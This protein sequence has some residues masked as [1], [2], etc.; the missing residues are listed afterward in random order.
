MSGAKLQTSCT[1]NGRRTKRNAASLKFIMITGIILLIFTYFTIL[2]VCSFGL[3]H[4]SLAH[5]SLLCKNVESVAPEP[6][7]LLFFVF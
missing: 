1:Q 6:F 2:N 7:F 3:V 4:M 5:C